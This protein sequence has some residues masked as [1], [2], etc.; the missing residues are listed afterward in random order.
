MNE[1]SFDIHNTKKWSCFP[2]QA[3][4]LFL[5]STQSS[6]IDFHPPDYKLAA[7]LESEIRNSLQESLS[8]WRGT[9]CSF[10]DDISNRL[11]GILEELEDIKLNGRDP[12]IGYF[13]SISSSLTKNREMFGFPLHFPFTN[14]QDILH[15]VEKTEIHTSKHPQV[16]FAISVRVFPY[17]SK[18]MSVWVFICTLSPLMNST[19]IEKEESFNVNNYKKLK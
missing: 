2:S 5:P 19:L 15:H 13:T 8:V 6:S 1:L 14:I 11:T 7:Q 18:V 16:E 10:R 12:K 9:P 3:E 4:K 17:E